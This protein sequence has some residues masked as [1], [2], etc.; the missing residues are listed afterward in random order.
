MRSQAEITA[1]TPVIQTRLAFEHSTPETLP[2]PKDI[3]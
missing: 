1:L 2:A 3:F